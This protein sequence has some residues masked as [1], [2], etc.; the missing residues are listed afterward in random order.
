M[1]LVLQSLFAALFAVCVPW[2]TIRLEQKFRLPT[3]GRG[4]FKVFS[5]AAG[6]GLEKW[7][8]HTVGFN[9]D[10]SKTFPLVNFQFATWIG[11][12]VV[13]WYFPAWTA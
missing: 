12:A 5:R 2:L 6:D 7:Y 1:E 8:Q 3:S 9:G 11:W 10:I 4:G 13:G